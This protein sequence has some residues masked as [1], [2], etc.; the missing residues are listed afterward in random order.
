MFISLFSSSRAEIFS[1]V[2]IAGQQQI[3]FIGTESWAVFYL[4]TVVSEVPVPNTAEVFLCCSHSRQTLWPEPYLGPPKIY[5]GKL[6]SALLIPFFWTFFQ[7]LFQPV[8]KRPTFYVFLKQKKRGS[9]AGLVHLCRK[10]RGAW[11][12]GQIQSDRFHFQL[13]KWTLRQKGRWARHFKQINAENTPQEPDWETAW[14]FSGF[15][16][17]H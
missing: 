11:R 14:R 4:L 5:N 8:L 12:G 16:Y 13:R 9:G 10:S 17:M 7:S 2:P 3:R 6:S 15:L 1:I